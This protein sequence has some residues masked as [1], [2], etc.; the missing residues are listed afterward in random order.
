MPELTESQEKIL[1]YLKE[2]VTPVSADT[3]AKRFIMSHSRV[4]STL[5]LLHDSGLATVSQVGKKKF[6][7]YKSQD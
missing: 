2:H 1:K 6:Y 5:K 4:S 7:Q 3:L